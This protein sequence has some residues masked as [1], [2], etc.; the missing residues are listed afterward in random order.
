MCGIAGWIGLIED[1]DGLSQ[2]LAQAL[3]HRG[4]DAHGERLFAQAGL[5]HTRLSILDLSPA[6]AQPMCNEDGSIWVVFNGEIYNHHA[7]R[8]DLES[9]GH[10]FRGRSDT[11]ILPHLYEQ[12]GADFALSTVFAQGGAGG[13]ALVAHI[14]RSNTNDVFAPD[15][16]WQLSTRA[17]SVRLRS[18]ESLTPA[19]GKPLSYSFT[20][21]AEATC[22]LDDS[23]A[24]YH[25]AAPRKRRG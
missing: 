19:S 4:P 9:Q 20:N 18:G 16:G 23:F 11:E 15:L 12:E 14:Q 13:V 6:G 10:K 17:K 25:P 3:R 7:L 21:G 24:I 8:D 2:R 5:V 1:G 22:L